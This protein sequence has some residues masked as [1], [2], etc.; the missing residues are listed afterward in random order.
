M[1]QAAT[2][3]TPAAVFRLPKTAYGIVLFL[4]FGTV[5][6]ALSGNPFGDD[7]NGGFAGPEPTLGWL[8]VLLVIPVIAAAFI[9][10]TATFVGAAGV[11]VRAAFGSR[12]FSWDDIRGLKVEGRDVYLVLADGAVRLPCVHVNQLATV[13]RA[14]DGRLPAVADPRPRYAP[15]RRRR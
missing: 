10:R 2:D 3:R 4:L 5:P 14:S 12:R 6:L 15:G 1:D 13:A 11:R 9:A 7:N 8:S